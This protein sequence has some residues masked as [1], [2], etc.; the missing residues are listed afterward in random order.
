[1]SD[2]KEKIIEPSHKTDGKYAILMETSE[3]EYESWYYFI[4]IEGNEENLKYLQN[5]LDKIDWHLLEDLCTFDLELD[6]N[7]SASTAKE[8]TKMDLNAYS[9]HRKFDGKLKKIDFEFKKHDGNETKMCKVFDILNF[10][11]IEDFID[12]EDIDE[13][14]LVDASD[15]ES[16]SESDSDSESEDEEQ[17]KKI[18]LSVMRS[19]LVVTPPKPSRKC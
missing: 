4:R 2:Y 15:N 12:D 7:V 10:G 3:E 6:N 14:D 11:K 16:I 8:M 19:R 5:Q 17:N 1:M 13:E 9:F 18:P